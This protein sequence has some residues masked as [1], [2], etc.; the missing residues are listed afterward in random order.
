MPFV[1]GV[2]F[3][4]GRYDLTIGRD[5][6]PVPRPG[7][8]TVLDFVNRFAIE[9]ALVNGTRPWRGVAGPGLPSALTGVIAALI[10]LSL[11]RSARWMTR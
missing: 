8:D 3:A 2:T 10:A 1:L 4:V 9:A 11:Q 5:S 6:D 7:T